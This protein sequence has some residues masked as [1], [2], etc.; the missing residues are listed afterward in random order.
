M[1]P[2]ASSFI[3]TMENATPGT[4]LANLWQVLR[5]RN[6]SDPST[7][8]SDR[9]YQIKRVLEGDYA[10][11]TNVLK[12]QLPTYVDDDYNAV[13]YVRLHNSRLQLSTAKDAFYK[14]TLESISHYALQMGLVN[15]LEGKWYPPLDRIRTSQ[16]E[17]E[18][19]VNFSR[20][21]FLIEVV[22]FGLGLALISLA[23]EKC[24]YLFSILR[25]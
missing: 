5:E 13:K 4:L 12:R 9:S 19:G 11:L 21:E 14:S 18:T 15:S 25:R 24:V 3:A 23:A 2:D 22:S 7:F 17:N 10:Y 8:S 1:A 16:V 20:L 6:R